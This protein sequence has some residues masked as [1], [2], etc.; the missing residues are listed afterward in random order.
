MASLW[1]PSAPPAPHT[2]GPGGKGGPRHLCSW[3]KMKGS[4]K[5]AWCLRA[6]GGLGNRLCVCPSTGCLL[7]FPSLPPASA[8]ALWC[9]LWGRGGQPQA[10]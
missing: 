3:R 9:L 1:F 7:R 2:Q 4:G 8:P 6:G 10:C 5:R